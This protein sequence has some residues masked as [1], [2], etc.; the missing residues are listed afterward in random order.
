MAGQEGFEPTTYG[1]GIRRSTVGATG[2][3]KPGTQLLCFAV[4]R[5]PLTGRAELL[6]LKSLARLRLR[7][8]RRLVVAR[9]ALVAC[10]RDALSLAQ[11][12]R[13]SW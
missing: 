8:F 9:T 10:E 13:G 2:L 3:I 1:F 11:V 5:V 4:Y 12:T 7:T 6:H